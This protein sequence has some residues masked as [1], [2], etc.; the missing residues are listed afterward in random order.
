MISG[1]YAP[2]NHT[3]RNFC[4]IKMF[5]SV[6]S[7]VYTQGCVIAIGVLL[8]QKKKKKIIFFNGSRVSLI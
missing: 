6:V 2:T 8:V 3:F 1:I 4:S 5:A 7:M